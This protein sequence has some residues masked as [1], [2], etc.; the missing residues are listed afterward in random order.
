MVS[1][2]ITTA[3]GKTYDLR[4]KKLKGNHP[5]FGTSGSQRDFGSLCVTLRSVGSALRTFSRWF[6][7]FLFSFRSAPSATISELINNIWKHCIINSMFPD[8]FFAK[9]RPALEVP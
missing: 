5:S 4:K 8:M 1:M 7:H 9:Y 6:L 3:L 2:S